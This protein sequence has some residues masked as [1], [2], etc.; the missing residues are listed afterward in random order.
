MRIRMARGI[1]YLRVCNRFQR[2]FV[3]ARLKTALVAWMLVWDACRFTA[4]TQ[5]REYMYA[6]PYMYLPPSL[7]PLLDPSPPLMHA[8]MQLRARTHTHIH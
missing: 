7:C 1:G 4:G 3:L 8:H 6:Y 2:R 5:I